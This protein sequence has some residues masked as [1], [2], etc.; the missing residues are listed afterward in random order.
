MKPVLLA[1]L[2][3]CTTAACGSSPRAPAASQPAAVDPVGT[4]DFT[5]AVEGTDVSGTITVSRGQNGLGG[6]ITSSVTEPMTI[7][8]VAVEG[9]VL[10][11]TA[12]T[13]DGPLT[14]TLT[15]TGNDFTGGWTLGSAMSGQLTGKR[16]TG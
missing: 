2:A 5:T 15:F 7:R 14:M 1:L 16:R 9:Q 12:D 3:A 13:P 4:F 11:I 6:S 8:T 10:T